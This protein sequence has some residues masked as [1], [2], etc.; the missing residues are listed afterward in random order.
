MP[1]SSRG[2][3]CYGAMEEMGMHIFIECPV[4]REVWKKSGVELKNKR[5]T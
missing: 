3:G 5:F 2:C 1:A 4:A